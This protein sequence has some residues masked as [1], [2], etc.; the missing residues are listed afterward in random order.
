M[1]RKREQEKLGASVR[2]TE[3]KERMAG[4]MRVR[5]GREQGQK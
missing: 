3:R 2:G 1:G 5:W 4:K